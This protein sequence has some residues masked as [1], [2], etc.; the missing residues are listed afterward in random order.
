MHV[1]K[2]KRPHEHTLSTNW[3]DE[4]LGAEDWTP[5]TGGAF[6]TQVT[7]GA[8]IKQLGPKCLLRG[9]GE[10]FPK[11]TMYVQGEWT[12]RLERLK[13]S[14]GPRW[15]VR[16]LTVKIKSRAGTGSSICK[17][18]CNPLVNGTDW[19][20]GHVARK[21]SWGPLPKSRLAVT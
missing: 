14:G 7:A 4:T 21:T 2:S 5:R 19:R 16:E 3:W 12:L 18:V 20:D 13:A 9:W 15:Q 6:H 11:W 10:N 8:K 1:Y 17:K